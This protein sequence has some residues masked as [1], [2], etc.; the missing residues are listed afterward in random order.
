MLAIISDVH[1]NLEAL[2]AVLDDIREQGVEKIICL[3][4]IVGY[5]PDPLLVTDLV[6]ERCET[7]VEGN[8]DEALVH[9]PLGFSPPAALVIDWTVERMRPSFFSGSELRRRWEW[10][11][12]LQETARLGDD[13]FVHGSPLDP[14]GGYILSTDLVFDSTD[15]FEQIFEHTDR[16]IFCG[17]THLPC[18]ITDDFASRDS[19]S[20][21]NEWTWEK[22]KAIVNTGSVGQPRD[23]D[24]RACYILFDGKKVTWRRVP[25]AFEK[26]AE[27]VARIL[28][29]EKLAE[30]LRIGA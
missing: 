17:H 30:R 24:N 3:G 8:H 19:A 4:D 7:V 5:G 25:Y 1:A 12:S 28:K 22:G 10:I 20:L 29:I 14:T 6:R 13:L 2:T 18:V 27:K 16:L 11:T 21:G 9:G 23:R 26:T 15:T